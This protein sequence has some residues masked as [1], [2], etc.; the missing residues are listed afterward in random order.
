MR[1]KVWAANGMIVDSDATA[2]IGER[3]SLSAEEAEALR[4]RTVGRPRRPSSGPSGG[5][6]PGRR[7]E[8]HHPGHREPGRQPSRGRAPH[9]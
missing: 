6:E 4:A 5:D 8:H 9:R 2:L 1:V 3:Y 7:G